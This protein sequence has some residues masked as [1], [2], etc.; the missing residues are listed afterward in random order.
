VLI[1]AVLA[2][3][4]EALLSLRNRFDT[5]ARWSFRDMFGQL[6]RYVVLA[7]LS[8]I[9]LLGIVLSSAMLRMRDCVSA[10]TCPA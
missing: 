9:C 4:Q 10:G 1:L 2:S 7:Q 5:K 8:A 6:H 3:S